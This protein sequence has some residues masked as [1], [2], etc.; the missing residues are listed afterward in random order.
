MLLYKKIFVCIIIL[1]L[2]HTSYKL[3]FSREKS[4]IIPFEGMT[5]LY[6]HSI[7]AEMKKYLNITPSS[8]SSVSQ[9]NSTLALRQYCIKSSYNSALSGKN[10]STD[11]IKYVLS[12]G[13]RFIDLEI[14]LIDDEAQVAY[15]NDPTFVTIKS[16]NYVTL[17]SILQSLMINAFSAPSPNLSDPL[18]IQFRVKSKNPKIYNLIGMAVSNYLSNKLYKGKV[19]GD[20]ILST[21]MN[22]VILIIDSTLSP[23]YKKIELYPKCYNNTATVLTQ[24]DSCFNLSQYVNIE[25]GTSN[26]R[27]YTYKSLLDQVTTPPILLDSDHSETDVSLFRLVCPD[28]NDYNNPSFSIFF[29]NYG[30]QFI[31]MRFYILDENL[32]LYEKFFAD[33]LTSFVPLSTKI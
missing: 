24:E 16:L 4:R 17:N 3:L 26:L 30:V 1:I 6:Q 29:S 10:I 25:S 28:D 18:F 22:K 14:F 13:C 11:A 27:R 23:D 20:T 12:R 5:N 32:T 21:L 15:S 8:V 31:S 19:T 2:S 33:N 7:D 9:N